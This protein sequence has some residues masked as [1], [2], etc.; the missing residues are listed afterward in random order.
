MWSK[1]AG[2]TWSAPQEI[3]GA[4]AWMPDAAADSQG[5]LY[6]AWD[7]YR[8]GNY[9]IFLRRVGAD[10]TLGPIQQVTKSP[11][12]Q[13]HASLAVD[14]NDRVWLAW[15]ESGAN[16]GKDYW[17]DD[18]WRGTTLYADRRPRVAV[19]DN[20]KW[21]QPVADPMA[22][23]PRRYDRY[24]S[25]PKLACGRRRPH[26]DGARIAHLHGHEPVR[27][28]GQQRPLGAVPDGVRRRPLA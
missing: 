26:L 4:N 15:D 18:T 11:R 2:D 10:G 24:V 25:E 14:G 22:A 23:M 17:R 8:T 20:G 21:W 9:D 3:S 1:L 13:A 12:F 5:N 28:L 16:W 7:S 6:V 27:F 19:L